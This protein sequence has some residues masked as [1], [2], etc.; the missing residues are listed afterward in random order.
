MTRWVATLNPPDLGKTEAWYVIDALPDSKIYAGLKAGVTRSQLQSA[1]QL[2]EAE[3]LLH[4]FTPQ[5]GDCVFIQAGTVHAIGAGLLVC[6]IQQASDTTFRLYD[7]NRVGNDGRP[8]PLHIQQGLDAINYELG[9]V[10]AV[11]SNNSQQNLIACDKFVLNRLAATQPTSVGGDGR[12]RILAVVDGA[13]AVQ[14]DPC[15]ENTLQRTI[16][17]DSCQLQ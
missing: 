3:K 17:S 8:R 13:I 1:I 15:P 11:V 9:P 16:D 12:L 2:G 7:W 5:S 10:N 6:E 4:S 14:G